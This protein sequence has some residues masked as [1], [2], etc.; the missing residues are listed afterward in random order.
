MTSPRFIGIR[1]VIDPYKGL[2][3][4]VAKVGDIYRQYNKDAQ[5]AERLRNQEAR[6]N[7]R[8]EMDMEQLEMGK[9]RLEMD[10]EQLGMGRERLGFD[11]ERFGFERTAQ[12]IAA[13]ERAEQQR[14]KDVTRNF[15]PYQTIENYGISEKF[16]PRLNELDQQV[17]D[18]YNKKT[19][20]TQKEA[21]QARLGVENSLRALRGGAIDRD[22][23]KRQY[24]EYLRRQGVPIERAVVL[25][26]AST[27]GYGSQAEIAA[28]LQEQAEAEDKRA[29]ELAKIQGNLLGKAISA[30]RA[31]TSGSTSGSK[32]GS[33]S[34]GIEKENFSDLGIAPADIAKAKKEYGEVLGRGMG[35]TENPTKAVNYIRDAVTTANE[36]RLQH[37]KQVTLGKKVGELLPLIPFNDAVG[38]VGST[39]EIGGNVSPR[40]F[41]EMLTFIED[42][43]SR[44]DFSNAAN[45]A[46][47]QE[48]K[49]E[50]A[51]TSGASRS[52]LTGADVQSIM[53]QRTVVPPVEQVVLDRIKASYATMF[54]GAFPQAAPTTEAAPRPEA[55]PSGGPA[56]REVDTITG[57]G[58]NDRGIAPPADGGGEPNIIGGTRTVAPVPV[59]EQPQQPISRDILLPYRQPQT[60]IE[61]DINDVVSRMGEI[62]KSLAGP[63]LG[64]VWGGKKELRQEAKTI[65]DSLKYLPDSDR[66]LEAVRTNA[67]QAELE[68]KQTQALA[69]EEQERTE[70]AAVEVK[71]IE[72]RLAS[73]VS[74]ALRSIDEDR[75]QQLLE[76]YP[77]L[78][79]PANVNRL[80]ALST[81]EQ[82]RQ[83]YR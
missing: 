35:W 50:P 73:N 70:R 47:E 65:R 12:Q 48:S 6:E 51:S 14:I 31:S 46:R 36:K 25:A 54:P 56:D 53:P 83:V 71:Q 52:V 21:E 61:A 72:K 81:L 40:N 18:Y 32:S 69:K 75:L 45:R 8:L 60:P 4:S 26:E 66:I 28:N 63:S 77:D 20:E 17:R 44:R 5:E 16:I 68:S 49:A 9:N 33:T 23:A 37:N 74:P 10:R 78:K 1:D 79:D 34:T 27:S 29:V 15:D 22:V 24:V 39:A 57:S 62:Q 80:S 38:W 67:R 30:N 59:P 76:V 3:D 55:L 58:T 43:A 7:K 64:W 82:I 2:Q 41:G 11:R 19:F 13:A 42:T